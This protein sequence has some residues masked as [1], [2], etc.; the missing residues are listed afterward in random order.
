MVARDEG[1]EDLGLKSLGMEVVV[2][3]VGPYFVDN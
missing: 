2:T 3:G 1:I